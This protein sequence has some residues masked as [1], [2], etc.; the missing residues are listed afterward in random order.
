MTATVD[1]RTLSRATRCR[2]ST[3]ESEHRGFDVRRDG[4]ARHEKKQHD[5]R[6]LKIVQLFDNPRARQVAGGAPENAG[7]QSCEERGQRHVGS[8]ASDKEQRTHDEDLLFTLGIGLPHQQPAGKGHDDGDCRHRQRDQEQRHRR[9]FAR[10]D[11]GNS[12][13]Q[14]DDDPGIEREARADPR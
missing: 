9:G 1:V 11:N 14:G 2:T 12:A 7:E 10:H 3:A 5:E 4:S 8:G 6:M 13:E